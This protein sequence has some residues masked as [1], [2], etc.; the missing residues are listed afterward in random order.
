MFKQSA[1]KF[2]LAGVSIRPGF[3]MP[4]EAGNPRN[5]ASPRRTEHAAGS[6]REHGGRCARL[7]V[8]RSSVGGS[9]T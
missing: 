7:I 2:R 4:H 8:D 9:S 3:E 5:D 6:R 1:E